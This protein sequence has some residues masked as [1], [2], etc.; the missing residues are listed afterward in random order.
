MSRSERITKIIFYASLQKTQPSFDIS[1]EYFFPFVCEHI[2]L[3]SVSFLFYFSP[4]LLVWVE[5]KSKARRAERLGAINMKPAKTLIMWIVCQHTASSRVML[6]WSQLIEAETLLRYKF[7]YVTTNSLLRMLHFFQVQPFYSMR[8]FFF[9]IAA[10]MQINVW[11]RL[12]DQQ[13]GSSLIWSNCIPTVL[14]LRH[15][16]WLTYCF[17]YLYQTDVFGIKYTA[18]TFNVSNAS[19]TTPADNN[20][21]DFLPIN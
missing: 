19:L 8:K 20:Y 12:T 14:S 4:L 9:L 21:Q 10:L 2:Q 18:K 16:H 13:I 3:S 1:R 17:T 5:K 7:T 6:R 11:G 15:T